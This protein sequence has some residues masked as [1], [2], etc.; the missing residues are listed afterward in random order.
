M[1]EEPDEKLFDLH[2]ETVSGRDG[3]AARFCMTAEENAC[4]FLTENTTGIEGER[5]YSAIYLPRKKSSRCGSYMVK[6]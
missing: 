2:R 3:Q 4:V 6:V 1:K 5:L